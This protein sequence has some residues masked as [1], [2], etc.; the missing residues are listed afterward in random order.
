M[1][2]LFRKDA[3]NYHALGR[4]GKIEVVPQNRIQLN[5]IFRWPIHPA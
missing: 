4:P 3:F 5:E 1:D 2:K